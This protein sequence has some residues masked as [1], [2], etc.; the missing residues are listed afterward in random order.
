M[1]TIVGDEGS[2]FD[3]RAGFVGVMGELVGD[4]AER[5]VYRASTYGSTDIAGYK[6]APG[7]L[8]Y[9]EKLEMMKNIGLGTKEPSP[10]VEETIEGIF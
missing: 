5:I 3:P 6:P 10:V 8:A 9:P 4:V 2:L 1:A 7:D